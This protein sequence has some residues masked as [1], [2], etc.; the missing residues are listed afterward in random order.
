MLLSTWTPLG[1]ANEGL[2]EG[3]PKHG[4]GMSRELGEPAVSAGDGG[5][6]R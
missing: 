1:A 5:D 2:P 4:P 3:A 6:G